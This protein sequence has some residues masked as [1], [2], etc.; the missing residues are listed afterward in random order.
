MDRICKAV[1]EENIVNCFKKANYMPIV[2]NE[3]AEAV[4]ETA[5]PDALNNDALDDETTNAIGD[6]RIEIS[7]DNDA[8]TGYDFVGNLFLVKRCKFA[9]K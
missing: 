3:E 7:V 1:S 5:E 2:V 4:P 6:L 8:N 9:N